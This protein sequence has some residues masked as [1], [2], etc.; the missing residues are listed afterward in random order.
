[1]LKITD[2]EVY[3][4]VIQAIKGDVYKRQ[5]LGGFGGHGLGGS[6][7]QGLGGS[8][9]HGIGGTGGQGFGGIGGVGSGFRPW[10]R[11]IS[12]LNAS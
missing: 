9:G 5:G 10:M 1:M 8:G 4:G 2:L 11:S 3:Y 12:H 6:G 7:G